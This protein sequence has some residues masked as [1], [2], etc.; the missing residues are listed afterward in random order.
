MLK[1][2]WKNYRRF[3]AFLLTLVMTCTNVGGNLGYVFG[4][5]EEEN[6]LFLI[7]GDELCEAIQNL[8]EYDN[9]F[10][11]ASLNLAASKKTIKNK[12]EKLLGG[13]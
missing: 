2:I 9:A 10:D 12:Y 6:A 8:G 11:F 5:G 7:D 3:V 4:A 1:I 13:G